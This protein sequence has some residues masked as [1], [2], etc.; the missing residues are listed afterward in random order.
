MKYEF[1]FS[2]FSIFMGKARFLREFLLHS[3]AA[4]TLLDL[5]VIYGS[6]GEPR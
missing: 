4:F 3:A 2:F 5:V 6:R 1:L